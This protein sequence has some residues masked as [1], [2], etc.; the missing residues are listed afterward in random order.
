MDIIFDFEELLKRTI[1]FYDSLEFDISEKDLNR[2]ITSLM[3]PEYANEWNKRNRIDGLKIGDHR[4]LATVGDAVC[5]AYI[6]LKE[7]ND[8]TTPCELSDKNK[9]GQN[10]NL[11]IVGRQLLEGRLFA[12][13][14]DI[15]DNNVKDYATAFEAVIGFIALTNLDKAFRIL[16]EYLKSVKII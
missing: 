10:S 13:N 4:A 8:E 9:L 5:A 15:R 2:A 6:M 16:D 3:M 7:F 12:L 14:N 1:A 11:R